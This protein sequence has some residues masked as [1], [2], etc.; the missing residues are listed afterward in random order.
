MRLTVKNKIILLALIPVIALVVVTI[1]ELIIKRS[2]S[3]EME[4]MLKV[5]ELVVRSSTS[6][7]EFQ[8]ERGASAGFIGSKG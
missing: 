4:E 2:I 6:V 5:A 7:H 3:S 8:K 1:N